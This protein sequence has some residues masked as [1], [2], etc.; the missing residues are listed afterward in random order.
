M[1][2]YLRGVTY[3][4]N[5]FIYLTVWKIEIPNRMPLSVERSPLPASV[6]LV[7]IIMAGRKS[8]QKHGITSSDKET[9]SYSMARLLPYLPHHIPKT[10]C[11]SY[12]INKSTF[13]RT[14]GPWKKGPMRVLLAVPTKI[15]VL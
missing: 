12:Y 14:K 6:M 10:N 15:K 8:M 3:K 2:K 11:N 4:E 5:K 1:M 13:M 7:C 9:M